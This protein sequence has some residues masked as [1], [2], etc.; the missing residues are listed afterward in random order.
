MEAMAGF[1][2][3][4]PFDR[5]SDHLCWYFAGYQFW[6]GKPVQCSEVPDID[7]FSFDLYVLGSAFRHRFLLLGSD[8]KL[9]VFENLRCSKERLSAE[10]AHQR[11]ELSGYNK[12][13]EKKESKFLKL[14]GFVWNPLSWVME[15]AAIMAIALANDGGKP[16]DWQD[17]VGIITLALRG[18]TT[19]L[20]RID[21][22]LVCFSCYAVS[23]DVFCGNPF[24]VAIG[25]EHGTSGRLRLRD[26]RPENT[27]MGQVKILKRR[28]E[29]RLPST[30]LV[31][32]PTHWLGL[33]LETVQK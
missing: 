16:P 14:S 11:L 31:L 19:G 12:L 7:Q 26:L 28:E 1:W 25:V 30:D 32:A 29:L 15:T 24:K 23:L 5:N 27:V 6:Q 2:R 17:F 18:F 9:V 33:D 4:S 20:S 10:S 22:C 8:L 13:K 3:R 21:L